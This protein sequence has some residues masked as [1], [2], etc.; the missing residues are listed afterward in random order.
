MG[1]IADMM[2]DG[3]LCEGCGEFL[4]GESFG[5]PR[6]CRGCSRDR[7]ASQKPANADS[8]GPIAK[9][10]LRWLKI[11]MARTDKPIGMYPGVY[12]DDA[13]G[14]IGKLIKRG[15]LELYYPHNSVHKVR[16]IITELGRAALQKHEPG[17]AA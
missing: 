10:Q 8:V 16:A 3:T 17:N 13:P 12:L 11:A 1:D 2:L 6:Y 15:L 5:V 9:N 7:G 4:D 14:Q